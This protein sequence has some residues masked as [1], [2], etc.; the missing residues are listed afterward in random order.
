MKF[1]SILVIIIFLLAF[2]HFQS[3]VNNEI[4]PKSLELKN[5]QE[6]SPVILPYFDLKSIQNEDKVNDRR[7]D[8]P[9]RFGY[10]FNVNYS[11]QNSGT[12]ENLNNGDRIWRIRFV[13]EGAK[14]MN[15]IFEDF[16]IPIGAKL[17]LYNNDKTDI[18]GAYTFAQ[19][20]KAK[21][22]GTWIVKGDDVVVEY[23]EPVS[24]KGKGSFIIKNITHG[25]R[26][27]VNLNASNPCNLDVNCSIGSD[28]DPLKNFV[29]KSVALVLVDG[30]AMCSGALIN[31][32]ANDRKPYFLT[33]DHCY[34][35][36]ATWAFRFNWI[37]T[38]TICATEGD[39][40]SNTDYHTIS[41]ATLRAR[42]EASDFCLVEINSDIPPDWGTVWAGW[43]RTVNVSPWVFGIHHPMG[44]IMKTCRDSSPVL[45]GSMWRVNN[46]EM[47]VT[48]S[49]SSG[50]P[51]YNNNGKII[52]QLCCGYGDCIDNTYQGGYNSY[53]RFDISWNGGGT[54][55]T[56]LENWLDP[57]NS[58]VTVLD[59]YPIFDLVTAENAF[60]D[61]IKVYPNPSKDIFIVDLNAMSNNLEYYLFS[62]DGSLISKGKFYKKTNKVDLSGK[63]IGT[64]LLKLVNGKT[65]IKTLKLLKQ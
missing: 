6:I 54:S 19:N 28:A 63:P 56:Q 4:Q 3:Q 5:L 22:L 36:P 21:T 8:M 38:N 50:S 27:G 41:G 60:L 32:T 59:S 35:D 18:L 23:Y 55:D 31:N 15:F 52:G 62:F 34:S 24:Q 49:G 37:S 53:G 20:N 16:F 1:N 48:E 44:D 42:R 65:T 61:Q 46:W 58:G 11:L 51:L 29:K 2:N 10:K 57:I 9:F 26:S 17:F 30:T 13:S 14:T 43:D 40:V 64:Y 33:A 47:G 7:L 25:Y 12:W 45:S 39:S